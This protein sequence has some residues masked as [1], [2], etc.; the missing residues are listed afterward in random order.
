[1]FRNTSNERRL[2]GG[3]K[4]ASL[5]GHGVSSSALDG[6][7]SSW[8]GL[9][10]VM[11]RPALSFLHKYVTGSPRTPALSEGEA[12]WVSGELRRGLDEE[13][14]F[15]RH[16]DDVVPTR[17]LAVLL[18]QHN[19]AAGG[20]LEPMPGGPALWLNAESLPSAEEHRFDPNGYLSSLRTFLSSVVRRSSQGIKPTAGREWG[21][22]GQ[23]RTWWGS[24]TQSGLLSEVSWV[25]EV[26]GR[27]CPQQVAETKAAETT[28]LF[29]QCSDRD[30]TLGENTGAT[31]HKD[32][33]AHN[34]GL[35]T[36]Q[37]TSGS[38]PNHRLA[39]SEHL[40]GA[41]AACCE[42][43]FLSPDHDN[44]YS[45]LEEERVLMY[46]M[47][48]SA[49]QSLTGV[50][51]VEE[52]NSEK[53]DSTSGGMEEVPIPSQEDQSGLEL[54]PPTPQ[55]QNKAIAYIM[56]CPCSDDDDKD[57]SSRSDEESTRDDDDGFDSSSDLSDITDEDEDS[58]SKI[59]S[60]AEHL[61]RSLCHN[62]D[63]YNPRNFS[64]SLHTGCTQPRTIPS[65]TPESSS[66]STPHSSP[67]GASD[68]WDDSTSASEVD[69]AE[70]LHLWSSFSCSSDPYSPFNFQAP[71]R[72]QGPSEAA[73]A[74][75]KSTKASQ[76]PPR[77]HHQAAS[78]PEY[79]KEEAEERL[80]SGFSEHSSG[81]S[82]CHSCTSTKKVRFSDEVEEFFA[83]CGEEEEEEDRRGPWEELARDRCRFLRRCQEVEQSIAYCLAPQHR[84][85]VY[86]R[87]T[88]PQAQD[89]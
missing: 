53:R 59:D 34:E 20:L 39:I 85:L 47:T 4:P 30:S 65:S 37:N 40:S 51:T 13:R 29:V 87:L 79:R 9:L 66:Q 48:A 22:D 55:C 62:P 49:E 64:A 14:E 26:T 61:W 54:V 52:Q 58:D 57:S 50:N 74:K 17:Q 72:T 70:S 2:T 1:M 71:L 32:Q 12:D 68:A 41:G 63:P 75:S 11:S 24:F 19:A 16:L 23:P 15:L 44:G 80:D 36:V 33:L 7:E 83:S 5:A 10:S 69:E 8:I 21:P 67:P 76:P 46:V 82:A 60:E 28:T 89:P 42:V 31:H 3:Q 84:S 35:H 81:S 25:E 73:W 78:P 38:T 43:L 88:I 86:Q 45:S 27:L 18:C 56:G 6:Q 77:H